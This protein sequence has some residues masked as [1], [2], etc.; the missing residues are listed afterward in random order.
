M[1]S[2][3]AVAITGAGLQAY[4]AYRRTQVENRLNEI[5]AEVA[6]RNAE[7][8]EIEGEYIRDAAVKRAKTYRKQVGGFI[9]TQRVAMG[10]SGL[11][12]DEGTFEDIVIDTAEQAALDEEAI[13]Y[14]G[15]VGAWRAKVAAQGYTTQGKIFSSQADTNPFLAATPGL[16]QG[17]GQGVRYYGAT[18]PGSSTGDQ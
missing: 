6:N 8:A 17:V 5:Q 16:L 13:L 4:S 15:D 12:V 7:T 2:V 14:E 18:R 10:S 1:C 9:G 11:V 3:A